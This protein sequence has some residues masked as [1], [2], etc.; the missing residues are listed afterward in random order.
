MAHCTHL[1]FLPEL[2][3]LDTDNGE[4]RSSAALRDELPKYD[5]I[6]EDIGDD[7]ISSGLPIHI[8]LEK[9]DKKEKRGKKSREGDND[10]C[11]LNGSLDDDANRNAKLLVDEFMKSHP[12]PPYCEHAV[13]GNLLCPV[14]IPQ[15]RPRDWKRGFMRA[16]APV[17]DDSGI[18]Q[19][20]FMDFLK[21][22][23]A[24][25]KYLPWLHA[26]NAAAINLIPIPIIPSM[27]SNHR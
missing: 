1:T 11:E 27:Y 10:E 12:S 20:T 21:T 14:I 26:I 13:T 15:R 25:N 4:S 16:Y 3:P 6:L 24:V 18:S 22:F 5:E 8:A 2:L 7:P 17:L 23:H 19:D 9:K